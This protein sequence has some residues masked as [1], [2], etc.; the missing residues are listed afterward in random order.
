ML[1]PSPEPLYLWKE[2]YIF[3]YLG[4][5]LPLIIT[6]PPPPHPCSGFLGESSETETKIP[7]FPRKWERAFG[8]LC[9]RAGGGGGGGKTFTDITFPDSPCQNFEKKTLKPTDCSF[10]LITHWQCSYI[11]KTLSLFSDKSKNKITKLPFKKNE[12]V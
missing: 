6:T 12:I 5:W 4:Y 3:P 2:I 7:L 8:P 11:H 10:Q 9:T 1:V